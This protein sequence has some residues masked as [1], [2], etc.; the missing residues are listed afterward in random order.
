MKKPLFTLNASRSQERI[1]ITI[2]AAG[3]VV[4]ALAAF[5]VAGWV[6]K[7]SD[8]FWLALLF[9]SVAL[10]SEVLGFNMAISVERQI[11]DK[12]VDR[13]T[14]CIFALAVCGIVNVVSGHNAW[15]GFERMMFA[16]QVADEQREID[17]ARATLQ[18]QIAG[19]DSQLLAARPPVEMNAGPAVRE[20]TRE[21]YQIEVSRLDPQR[22]AAQ[23]R[24]DAMPLAAPERHIASDPL[25]WTAFVLIEIMK[26]TVLWGI[27]AGLADRRNVAADPAATLEQ[28]SQADAPEE[29]EKVTS[30]N[31][32]RQ[33]N[34]LGGALGAAFALLFGWGAHQDAAAQ[35]Q[36]VEP[37]I[38]TATDISQETFEADIQMSIPEDIWGEGE[39][40]P[41]QNKRPMFEEALNAVRGNKDIAPRHLAAQLGVAPRTG[42]RWKRWAQAILASEANADLLDE[43]A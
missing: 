8:S 1:W 36:N 30:I 25:V 24:L 39:R 22:R 32:R 28:R 26:A 20:Q 15:T 34:G 9:C 21:V 38:E 29:E 3:G 41:R 4:A 10:C 13:A 2:F 18:L 12:R 27:G 17:H 6:L 37:I 19:I 5:N 42:E 14:A 33:R 16:P 23:A 35:T 7:W 40:G 31:K 43:F 11:R